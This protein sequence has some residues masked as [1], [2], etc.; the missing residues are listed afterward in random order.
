MRI[1]TF[2]VDRDTYF[3]SKQFQIIFFV[4]NLIDLCFSFYFISLLIFLKI[5]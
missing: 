5:G 1:E 3:A 2:L 4:I